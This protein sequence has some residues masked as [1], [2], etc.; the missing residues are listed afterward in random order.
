MKEFKERSLGFL[1]SLREYRTVIGLMI[2]GTAA[3][4]PAV[5]LADSGKI[6]PVA[7]NQ[8]KE[9]TEQHRQRAQAALA[10]AGEIQKEIDQLNAEDG[11]LTRKIRARVEFLKAQNAAKK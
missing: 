5:S 4:M 11:E 2:A 9:G 8:Y 6:N 3:G 10:Q 7:V 1:Q